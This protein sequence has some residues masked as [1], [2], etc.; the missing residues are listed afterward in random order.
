VEDRS[1]LA[2]GFLRDCFG[3]ISNDDLQY[4]YTVPFELDQ[5]PAFASGY[6]AVRYLGRMAFRTESYLVPAVAAALV[7]L[8]LYIWDRGVL[9]Y[10]DTGS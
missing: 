4:G 10:N 5:P 7:C 2:P 3:P 8:A 1:I 9:Q 6:P